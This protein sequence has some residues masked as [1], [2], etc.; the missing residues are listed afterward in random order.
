MNNSGLK[1]FSDTDFVKIK[2]DG[3]LLPTKVYG[4][5]Y[6]KGYAMYVWNKQNDEKKTEVKWI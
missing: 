2:M 3:G 1:I 6:G 4:C 5:R